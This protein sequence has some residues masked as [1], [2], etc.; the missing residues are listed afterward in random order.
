M[1]HTQLPV[2]QKVILSSDSSTSLQLHQPPHPGS[3]YLT[4]WE[5]LL[6]LLPPVLKTPTASSRLFY[7]YTVEGGLL[8]IQKLQSSS[9]LANPASFSALWGLIHIFKEV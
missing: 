9:R 7:A 1:A 4:H 6:P 2:T 5:G 3:H 8:L